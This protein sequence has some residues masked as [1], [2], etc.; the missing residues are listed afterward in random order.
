MRCS[1][2]AL[3]TSEFTVLAAVLPLGGG[4]QVHVSVQQHPL[5]AVTPC[6]EWACLRPDEKRR[7][8]A[9][10]DLLCNPLLSAA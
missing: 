3:I 6:Q 1:P 5:R 4:I 8:M 10:L 9:L 7:L 2:E